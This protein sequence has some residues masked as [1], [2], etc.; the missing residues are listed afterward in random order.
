MNLKDLAQKPTLVELKVTEPA[1]VEK[2]GDELSFWVYDRQPIDVFA[3][4]ATMQEA[5]PLEFT[6]M[7]AQLILDAKGKPVMADGKVLPIDVLTEAVK[8]IGDTLGK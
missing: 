3:K 8:L 2:Y 7:L 6:D 5:N 4:L 1:I